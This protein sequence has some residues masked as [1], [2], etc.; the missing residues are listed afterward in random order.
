M[1]ADSG[2]ARLEGFSD[3]VF[4]FAV[5]LLVVSLEVP[6]TFDDLIAALRGVPV[7][8]ITFAILLSV[9]QEHHR[10]FRKFG[11]SDG[12]TI[13]LNGALLFTVMVYIYPLKFLFA[14]LAGPKGYLSGR[15]QMI[16]HNQIV[17][18][19]V[20]YGVGFMAM[21]ALLGALYATAWRRCRR[22]GSAREA[23]ALEGIGHCAIYVVVALLSVAV[24]VIGG[25]RAAVFSGL[26]YVLIAPFHFLLRVIARQR[27]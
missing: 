8:A 21:F 23:E 20:L 9:W 19:M 1:E 13:W 7:F 17:P 4:G 22:A 14:L 24:A 27:R 11:A 6:S 15:Q 18:A 25:P 2:A 3:A 16:H 12:T 10:F 5:T 26:C